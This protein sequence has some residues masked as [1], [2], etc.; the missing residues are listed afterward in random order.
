MSVRLPSPRNRNESHTPRPSRL[1]RLSRLHLVLAA[2]ARE[3]ARVKTGGPL[4]ALDTTLVAKRTNDDHVRRLAVLAYTH[5]W[6]EFIN[7]YLDNDLL[8]PGTGEDLQLYV[9]IFAFFA[10][11][12]DLEDHVNS[13]FFDQPVLENAEDL[14]LWIDR[15]TVGR[16]FGCN[17]K[18]HVASEDDQFGVHP[19]RT[20]QVMSA[21]NN[22]IS[23]IP[24]NGEYQQLWRDTLYNL[25]FSLSRCAEWYGPAPPNQPVLF[26]GVSLP[27][28]ADEHYLARLIERWPRV[29][30]STSTDANVAI[31]FSGSDPRRAVL[32]RFFVDPGVRVV[33]VANNLPDM[34]TCFAE[35]E[36]VIAPGAK[37][38][39]SHR[40]VESSL[41]RERYVLV[42][43]G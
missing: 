21:I 13:F 42:S 7:G 12:E 37:Y 32:F 17:F 34:W 26:H 16:G 5:R 19:T 1:P 4:E 43:A 38:T 27:E 31:E 6:D 36:I 2:G 40:V 11:W 23:E 9:G 41:G 15:S 18:L 35:Y 30:V 39:V 8:I 20:M 29:F 24:T 28:D 33:R 10:P 14:Q 3:R 25:T 22:I